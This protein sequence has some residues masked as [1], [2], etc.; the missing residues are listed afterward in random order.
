[1]QKFLVFLFSVQLSSS[2]AHTEALFSLKPKLVASPTSGVSVVIPDTRSPCGFGQGE[3]GL[4]RWV[5]GQ[6]GLTWQ[7]EAAPVLSS[8]ARLKKIPEPTM[9]A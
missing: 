4:V 9:E 6:V 7:A 8:M 1:M 5:Y 3:V 2:S